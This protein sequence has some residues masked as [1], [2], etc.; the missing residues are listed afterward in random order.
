MDKAPYIYAST[1]GNFTGQTLVAGLYQ[2][3]VTTSYSNAQVDFDFA[4]NMDTLG[5]VTFPAGYPYIGIINGAS[6]P[7]IID[8]DTLL[9]AL[10]VGDEIDGDDGSI[11][12][13]TNFNGSSIVISVTSGYAL[14]F[15]SSTTFATTGGASGNVLG[16]RYMRTFQGGIPGQFYSS[17]ESPT[18]RVYPPKAVGFEI[19][20]PTPVASTT[21]GGEI[22]LENLSDFPLQASNYDFIEFRRDNGIIGGYIIRQINASQLA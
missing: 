8:Y 16:V 20:T 5:N 7:V 4:G 21:G 9:G 13:I 2:N 17:N 14:H 3:T 12:F 15:T 11:G 22:C 18:F 1:I 6:S 10:N 19:M